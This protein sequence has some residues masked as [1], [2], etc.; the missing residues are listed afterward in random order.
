MDRLYS[1]SIEKVRKV[2]VKTKRYL[3]YEIDWN[4]R[5]ISITG[6]RGTGKTILML[7]QIKKLGVDV[8]EA[9]YLSLDNL[10]FTKNSLVDFAYH[11]T[12]RGGKYLFLDEVHKY[13]TWSTEIK[14]IYDIHDDLKIVFTGSSVLEIDK[15]DA[16]LSRRI[17][18]YHM[19]GMSFREY[20]ELK[21]KT[22]LPVYRL[23]E[24]INDKNKISE[25]VKTL[26]EKPIKYFEEYLAYG[27]FPYIIED[28][29]GYY[30]RINST[31]N[32]I[33]ESDLIA[34]HGIDFGSVVKLKKLLFIIST[35]VPFKPNISKLS[36]QVGVSRETIQRYLFFLS[37]AG[38]INL[39]NS[40]IH[41]I[42][43][44]NK[45]DKIYLNN[46]NLMFALGENR[47]NT[48]TIRET[49]FMNQ[50]MVRHRINYTEKGDFL[51][52]NEYIFEIGGKNKNKQQ[53]KGLKN[54]FI[55]ADNIEHKILNKL[56]LWYFGLMY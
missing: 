38:L 17:M 24:I 25:H 11:F 44:M 41:G 23:E 51:V 55:V 3:Y 35:I 37:K 49:F 9:I 52:D 12:S 30:Q 4:N 19:H 2:P 16:D 45:P 43:L 40:D 22:K 18:K 48:G 13:S 10:Y 56:P 1:I 54:A 42:G 8:T 26:I 46:T 28:K 31:I 36:R 20:I 50:L 29:S 5:L 39:L 6:A 15:G 7:Q 32:T 53:I 33:L 14:N 34:V 27:Y 47:I 21:Y